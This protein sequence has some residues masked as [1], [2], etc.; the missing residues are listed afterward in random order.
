MNLLNSKETIINREE[1][2]QCLAQALLENSIAWALKAEPVV[3]MIYVLTKEPNQQRKFYTYA[4]LREDGTPFYI[5]RGCGRRAY[6]KHRNWQPPSK[7]RILILKKDL[8]NDEANKHEIYMI[9]VLGRK[10]DGGI[11]NNL[12]IGGSQAFNPA[13]STREKMSAWQRNVPTPDD[14]KRKISKSVAALP[15]PMWY[16]KDGKNR[17]F[18]ET[19]PEGWERGRVGLKNDWDRGKRVWWCNGTTTT[20]CAEQPGPEWKRGRKW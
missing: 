20:W 16:N 17:F 3:R 6:V 12:A 5:G 10:C 13:P 9:S 2:A 18:R 1:D 7:D 4:W 15:K 14:V 19:P 8:T 11:L